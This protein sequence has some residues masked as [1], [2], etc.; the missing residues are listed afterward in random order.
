MMLVGTGAEHGEVVLD[1]VSARPL[2]EAVLRL[3][4]TSTTA[5]DGSVA[6]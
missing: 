2:R 1:G 5:V 4:V 6:T 3:R